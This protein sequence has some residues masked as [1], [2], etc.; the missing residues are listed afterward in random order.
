MCRYTVFLIPFETIFSSFLVRGTKISWLY[1]HEFIS[2][3]Y[4][5]QR[6]PWWPSGQEP[7]CQCRRHGFD[8]WV[9]KIPWRRKWQP[10]PVFLPGKLH[11]QRRLSMDWATVHSIVKRRTGLSNW[12]CTHTSSCS[13]FFYIC[14]RRT[15]EDQKTQCFL[16]S[17][18]EY[19]TGPEPLS[20]PWLNSEKIPIFTLTQ[21]VHKLSFSFDGEST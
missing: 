20:A 17:T 13:V 15:L 9:G 4:P 7:A 6:L 8:P 10:T 18:G 11:E 1:M 19:H 21:I 16:E 3:L 14:S 5:L 12:A 2:G